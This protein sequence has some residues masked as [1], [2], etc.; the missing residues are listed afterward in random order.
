MGVDWI[1]CRVEADCS[2]EELCELVRRE[3]MHF[4][5]SG[6][7]MATLLDPRISFSKAEQERIRQAY[8]ELGP[9]HRRLLF[10]RES[11]L[12]SVIGSEELFSIEW[13]HDAERTILPWEL[14]DQLAQWQNYREEVAR[15]KHRPFLQQLYIY[16]RL[17]ELVTVDLANFIPL[18][19]RALTATSSW[20][21]RRKLWLVVIRSWRSRF[22]PFHL[23][24]AGRK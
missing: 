2:K 9:L 10:K 13:R 18:V 12:V 7:S 8:L 5:A 19:Q 1:P 24:H 16:A 4:R 15:G 21:Q 3:A 11:H 17:H 22:S 20:A 23:R 14:C 6:S